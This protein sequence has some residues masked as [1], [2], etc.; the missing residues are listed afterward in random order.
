MLYRYRG[1]GLC[2]LSRYEYCTQVKIE[3]QKKEG[4]DGDKNKQT[5]GRKAGRVFEFGKGFA[6]QGSHIQRLRVKLCTLKLYQTPP[7]HPGKKPPETDEAN[8]QKWKQKADRFGTY[9]LVLFCPEIDLYEDGQKIIINTIGIR[10][11]NSSNI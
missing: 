7:P 8:L 11:K 3:K 2:Q 5:G 4:N 10:S 9:F 1:A 6:L